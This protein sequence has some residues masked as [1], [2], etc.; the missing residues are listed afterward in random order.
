MKWRCS[1][2]ATG[3]QFAPVSGDGLAGAMR[4]AAALFAHKTLWRKLQTNGM[5]T[6]VCWTQ[7]GAAT[8]HLYREI[9]PVAAE[10][11]A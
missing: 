7:P 1:G 10:V 4:K 6:D 2:L 3:L 8:P 5:K 11:A 9:A